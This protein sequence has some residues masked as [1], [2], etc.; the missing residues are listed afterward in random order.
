MSYVCPENVS[1]TF[2]VVVH[3]MMKPSLPFDLEPGM[4]A[5]IAAASSAGA[6]ISVVPTTRK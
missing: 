5:W 1:E 3:G 6:M 4:A 2:A